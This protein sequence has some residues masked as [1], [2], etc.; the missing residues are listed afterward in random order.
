MNKYNFFKKSKSNK[1]NICLKVILKEAFLKKKNDTFYYSV[2]SPLCTS[3]H[4][5]KAKLKPCADCL[6]PT[7]TDPLGSSLCHAAGP[8]PGPD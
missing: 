1:L 2:N 7:H 6:P 8:C 3:L 4:C 5:A